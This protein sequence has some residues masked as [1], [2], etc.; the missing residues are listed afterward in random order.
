M[1]KLACIQGLLADY[2]IAMADELAPLYAGLF[3]AEVPSQVT[4]WKQQWAACAGHPERIFELIMTAGA[5]KDCKTVSDVITTL[6]SRGNYAK[7][8]Q[9][10]Y[11]LLLFGQQNGEVPQKKDRYIMRM[12]VNDGQAGWRELRR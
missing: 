6:K 3:D 10:K 7:I 1:N 11:Q 2:L 9:M 5:Y 4:D 8:G 12:S